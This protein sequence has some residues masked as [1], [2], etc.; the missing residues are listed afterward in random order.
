MTKQNKTKTA[1]I[2]EQLQE[3]HPK[4]S[5]AVEEGKKSKTL[6]HSERSTVLKKSICALVALTGGM[7]KNNNLISMMQLDNMTNQRSIRMMRLGIQH[8]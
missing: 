4:G 2:G 6:E 8:D 7:M 5:D 1:I 3:H